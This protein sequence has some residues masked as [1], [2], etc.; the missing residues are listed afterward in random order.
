MLT[1]R[2]L[3][4]SS[5]SLGLLENLHLVDQGLS[6]LQL[7]LKGR[8][9]LGDLVDVGCSTHDVELLTEFLSRN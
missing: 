1:F 7:A 5:C 9:G 3:S 4:T 8:H 2:S 6:I